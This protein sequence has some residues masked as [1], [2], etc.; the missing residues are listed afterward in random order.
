MFI[1]KKELIDDLKYLT[2]SKN[3]CIIKIGNGE[4]TNVVASSYM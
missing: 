3:V 2:I 1:K 4:T